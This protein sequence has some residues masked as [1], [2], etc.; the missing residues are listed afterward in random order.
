MVIMSINSRARYASRVVAATRARL[1]QTCLAT[2]LALCGCF[3]P[4]LVEADSFQTIFS[5]PA[6]DGLN[7]QGGLLLAR[8]GNF[9]G[10][11]TAGGTA[12]GG[13]TVF[14]LTPTG[15]LTTLHSF[16]GADGRTPSPATLVQGSDGGLYGVTSFG[17]ASDQGTIYKITPD[18]T[19]T[20]LHSF[21]G[22]DGSQPIG[23]LMQAGDGNFYGTTETGETSSSSNGSVFRITPAGTFTALHFFDGS[24]GFYPTSALVQGADGGLYGTT[25]SNVFRITQAGSFS[26]VCA[27]QNSTEQP[28]GLTLGSDGNFY[29]ATTYGGNGYGSFFRLTPSGTLTTLYALSGSE[30]EYPAA[31]LV[32]GA[33]GNF[34]GTTQG[35]VDYGM[36]VNIS[37]GT[38]FKLTPSGTFTFLHAFAALDGSSPVG[39]LEQ[40]SDG[41]FY[42]TTPQGGTSG[43]GTV[44][45]ITP[46]GA[47][48]GMLSFTAPIGIG[49]SLSLFDSDGNLYGEASG[50]GLGG[51]DFGTVFKFTTSG[52]ASVLHS[53][54]QQDGWVP[55]GGLT[56]GSDGRYYGTTFGST[57]AG[58]PDPGT[59]FTITPDGVFNPLSAFSPSLGTGQANPACRLAQ[60][61][62]GLF[63]GTTTTGGAHQ[64]GTVFTIS[65][66]GVGNS[67]YSFGSDSGGNAGVKEGLLSG[68][69]GNLYGASY[70]SVYRMTR[71]GN[72][73]ILHTFTGGPVSRLVFGTDG[74]LYGIANNSNTVSIFK[75][76]TAGDFSTLYALSPSVEAYSDA[77]LVLGYDGN[78]YGATN[79]GEAPNAGTVFRVSPQGAFT[80]LHIFTSNPFSYSNGPQGPMV[81]GSDGYLYGTS[82]GDGSAGLGTVFRLL[83][84]PAAPSS[85]SVAPADGSALL[86]WGAAKGAVSY[87]VYQGATAGGESTTPVLTGLTGT[88]ATIS[89]LS[90]GANYYFIVESV[91]DGGASLPSSEASAAPGPPQAPSGFSAAAGNALVNVRWNAVPGATSYNVYRGTAAGG[92]SAT[93]VVSGRTVTSASVYNLSNGTKYYF[94]VRAV[95]GAG[96]GPA[97]SEASATPV[98][99][100]PAPIGVTAAGGNGFVNVRWSASQ[101]A[102]S[103]NVYEGVAAGGESATPVQ[104]GLTGNSASIYNL[105][106]GATYY[107]VVRGVNVGGSSP[108]SSEVSATPTSPPAAPTGVTAAAGNGFVNV[109]WRAVPG[110]TSYNV[111]RGTTADGESSAPV[112]SGVTGS[113]AS[114]YN[115]TNGTTYYFVVRAINAGGSSPA[116]NEASVS[117]IGPPPA[118]TGVIATSGN[119]LVNV[120]WSTAPGAVSYNVFQGTAPGGE[121]ATPVQSGLTGTSATISS[122]ANGTTYYFVIRAVNASGAS[123]ASSE[124]SATPSSSPPAPSGVTAAGGNGLVNVRWSATPRATSYNVYE[125]ATAGGE[126]ATPVQ[127]GLSDTSASIYGLNNGATY[128]FFV[129][130]VNADGASPASNEVSAM[131]AAP[132]PAPT[133][134]TA[135]GG[136]AS[137]ILQWTAAQGATSY[138]V[139]QS[140]TAGRESATPVLSGLKGSSAT[141]NGLTNGATYFFVVR[142]LNSSSSS[143]ASNEASATPEAPTPAPTNVTAAAGNGFIHVTWNYVQGTS[144][145]VYQG[146]VAGGESSTPVISG[147][148]GSIAS[149]YN[150]SNG[151][152][153]YFVVRAVG[154]G[155][156]SPASNEVSAT[157]TA[158]PP[159]PAAPT[160]LTAVAG[161]GG[162]VSMQ[163]NAAQGATSYI[164]YYGQRPDD[165]TVPAGLGNVTSTSLTVTLREGITY[166][167]VVRGE[168][169]GGIGPASNEVSATPVAPPATNLAAAAGNGCVSLRWS[170]PAGS[171]GYDVLQGTTP[172]GELATPGNSG[173]TATSAAICDL[174]NG[175]TYY[176]AVRPT[177]DNGSIPASNEVSATPMAPP[178]APTGVAAAAGNAQVT[179]RWAAVAGAAHYDVYEGTS[180]GA[181]SAKPVLAGVSATSATVGDLTNGNTYYFVVRAVNVNGAVSPASSE[182]SAT[183]MASP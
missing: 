133:G 121:S 127:S 50:G 139:Y 145:N 34:Y 112:Q 134:V 122:L 45:K 36:A 89:G 132:P 131:P 21:D 183:P 3:A 70:S 8:D 156:V 25:Y 177:G 88:S 159:P 182:V 44:F 58:A 12:G 150:L 57:F 153:Y 125:G 144:Y 93:P 137:V 67:L 102:T 161:N 18:G 13:G 32:L 85:L 118:P 55:S 171:S 30:S 61:V 152:T 54:N 39:A 59:V 101:G 79:S 28:R 41:N 72:V 140:T 38:V 19:F 138:N 73:T 146:T 162:V 111:Y 181:E 5:F 97:S 167:F 62:N 106:N 66:A 147:T 173:F 113:G 176:F 130:A 7:P 135:T 4:A 24:D 107:F 99:P 81:L 6:P 168:N 109:R 94:T 87:S 26:V 119:G 29:G 123:P 148:T 75:I 103:Y 142:A 155:G 56:L 179:L 20:S 92:E 52:T 175:T 9:Y 154:V 27:F 84:P 63:Y 95:D 17:G 100:P 141:V 158:P 35:T 42:G 77:G 43:N 51:G 40:G 115:L 149:I 91:N 114:I 69:D 14:K 71:A 64:M 60:A 164:A 31:S 128:Y 78:F 180:A 74:Y 23:G 178:P 16:G 172:G 80:V 48:T 65:S 1:L 151:T 157:P 37:H 86:Q 108:A 136:N 33:D 160:G 170:A 49:P 47:F 129:R 83:Q 174:S 105:S 22:S 104:S 68:S 15:V 90:N 143:P 124:V 120:Q 53:F 126:S 110:A 169:A 117:P 82:S 165:V 46:A 116:S 163:W 2:V 96:A 98:A 11:T 166:Y 10:T 76:S